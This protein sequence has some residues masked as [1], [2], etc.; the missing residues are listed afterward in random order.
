MVRTPRPVPMTPF[1]SCPWTERAHMPARCRHC[2]RPIPVR[3]LCRRC[4]ARAERVYRGETARPR[5]RRLAWF[6]KARVG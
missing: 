2:L 1:L 4:A 3:G 5:V 6:R